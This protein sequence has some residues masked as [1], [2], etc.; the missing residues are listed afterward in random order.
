MNAEFGSTR[1][2]ATLGLSTYVI[3]IAF[4]PML[5]GP[6]SEFYGR[7][8]I[9][10]ISWTLYVV[11]VVPSAVAGNIATMI[12]A[13]FFDGL[14]GSAFLSVAGGSVGDLF[15]RKDLQKPMMAYSMTPFIGPS[16]GPLVGGF[17]NSFLPWRWTFYILTIWATLVLLGLV[18]LV[19]ET[20]RKLPGE[21]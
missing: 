18:V 15:S 14:A 20:Y 12:I 16:I 9:Y 10:L 21:M 3:G 6:L 7:R 1:I 5:L 19:P 2:E 17:I 8:P 13:R 4:G 11:W